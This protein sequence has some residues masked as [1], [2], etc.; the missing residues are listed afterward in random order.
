M[1]LLQADVRRQSNLANSQSGTSQGQ[2]V[3]LQRVRERVRTLEH[4]E[5]PSSKISSRENATT[6][7]RRNSLS[8]YSR[9][10]LTKQSS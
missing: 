6:N 8:I 2:E 1:H 9:N 5:I 4:V 3:V 7:D 10:T